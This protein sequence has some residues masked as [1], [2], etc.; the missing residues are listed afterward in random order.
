MYCGLSPQFKGL[1]GGH[2]NKIFSG[3]GDHVHTYDCRIGDRFRFGA[4]QFFFLVRLKRKSIL[5]GPL[6]RISLQNPSG[7]L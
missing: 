1:P 3:R 4:S 5:P 7:K 2:S 6:F